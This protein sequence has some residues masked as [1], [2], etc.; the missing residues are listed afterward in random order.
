MTLNGGPLAYA[1]AEPPTPLTIEEE[2][3]LAFAACGVTG[4]VLGDLPYETGG[5]ANSGGGN[6]M[7]SFTGRTIASGDAIHTTAVVV[8]N[9]EGAWFL[10]RPRDHSPEELNEIIAAAHE[11]RLVD[12]YLK[13]RIRITD[14]RPTLPREMPYIP[15]FNHWSVN[16]PGT[17]YFM[18]VIEYTTIMFSMLLSAL[19]EEIGMF[20]LDERNGFKPAG[21]ASFAKSKGGHLHDDPSRMVTVGYLE[22]AAQ[23]FTALEVGAILQNLGLMTA[24]LGLGGF[25]N[26]AIHPD[27]LKAFGFQVQE[28][29]FSRL[30]AASFLER[31]VMEALGK[32]LPVPNTVGFEFNGVSLVKPFCR[33]NYP[34]MEAAVRAW[35]DV[36]YAK[37]KGTFRDDK[38]TLFRDAR[39]VEAGIPPYSEGAINAAIAYC[40]Y[41]D[42]RYGRFPATTAPIATLLGFQA[43]RLDLAFYETKYLPE[44]VGPTQRR[45][46]E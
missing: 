13:S 45:R 6:I 25:P 5:M 17:T 32:D 31:E 26:S 15:P 41:L 37:A 34:T 12:I 42:E 38:G 16:Q 9:D 43:H 27:W 19:G 40:T 7:Y 3:A 44:A 23:Q 39:G 4:R 11:G 22:A 35:L 29:P 36:K 18:P 1:S 2:A 20:V 21:L 14:Q 8:L 28:I 10:K 30:M 24:A 46:E 33:P